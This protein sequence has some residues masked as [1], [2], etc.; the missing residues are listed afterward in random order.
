NHDL[1]EMVDT[2]DEWI[3]SRTGIRERRVAA[4]D[5]AVSDLALAAAGAALENAGIPGEDVDAVICSTCTGDYVLPP[6]APLVSLGIG[7]S[8]SMAYDLNTACSGWIYGLNQA[9]ALVESAVARTVLVVGAEVLSR[10]VNW[11]D[12]A[13]CILFGDG[14]GAAIVTAS[15]PDTAT[16]FL[17]FDLG[18]DG[19]GVPELLVPAGG[20]RRPAHDGDIPPGDFFIQMNGREVFRFASRVMVDSATRLLEAVEMSIDEVDLM[21]PHQANIRIIDHAVDRL[22]IAP[23]KVFNNLE[24]YGNTSSA[25]IPLAMAEARDAGALRPGDLVLQVGFGAGLTWG[26]TLVR[27]EPLL[28]AASGS[29]A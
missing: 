12:R 20:G 2:T 16:G 17:G 10:F 19:A 13:T 28:P 24:R 26:S 27:Y 11:E 3:V 23:E 21:I 7:A 14:A 22:G 29:A 5:Q 18:A 6:T 8:R 25:S 15:D 1:E 9:Y 4:P